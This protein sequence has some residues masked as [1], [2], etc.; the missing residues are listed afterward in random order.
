MSLLRRSFASRPCCYYVLKAACCCDLRWCNFHIKPSTFKPTHDTRHAFICPLCFILTTE[1]E[2]ASL[3]WKATRLSL[4]VYLA[5]CTNCETS[6]SE[7]RQLQLS[8][9]TTSGKLK[10]CLCRTYQVQ[11]FHAVPIMPNNIHAI[12][13]YLISFET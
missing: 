3:P 2:P 12:G 6:N 1:C 7:F 9:S 8:R 4:D 13:T 11:I 10:S 5:L